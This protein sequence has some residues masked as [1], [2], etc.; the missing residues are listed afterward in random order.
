MRRR[1]P[2]AAAALVL[3]SL[4]CRRA[5]QAHTRSDAQLARPTADTSAAVPVDT[6]LGPTATDSAALSAVNFVKAFYS[7][8][9]TRDDNL[10]TVVTERADVFGSELLAALRLDL[11][12]S[13]ANPGEIV[14]LDWDPLTGGQDPCDPYQVVRTARRQDTVLVDV[15][16]ACPGYAD[17]ALPDAVLMLL[18][19]DADWR[20]VDIRHGTDTGTLLGDLA[21]LRDARH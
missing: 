6:A 17:R 16:S 11:E 7:W 3:L 10:E 8:Y 4:S 13:R 9:A 21:R 19:F 15:R 5:E 14:G 20:I 18:R 2:N 1:L 12:A